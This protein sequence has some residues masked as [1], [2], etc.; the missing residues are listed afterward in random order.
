MASQRET[1]LEL[2]GSDLS[3]LEE[4]SQPSQTRAQLPRVGTIVQRADREQRRRRAILLETPP[5]PPRRSR[6]LSG[7]HF[8]RR[9]APATPTSPQGTDPRLRPRTPRHD[10]GS[11]GRRRPSPATPTVSRGV[12]PD[13]GSP[14]REPVVATTSRG[15]MEAALPPPV[16]VTLPTGEVAE[17]P[18]F[19]A[20]I[21]RNYRMRVLSG[22]WLIR[23]DHHGRPRSSRQLSARNPPRNERG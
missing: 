13:L 20:H 11:R 15:D 12:D 18:H 3:D 5:P 22:K 14:G 1:L 23:F 2:F 6:G 16:R 21:L 8:R 10:R 7:T 9:P 19:A 4:E 17:V